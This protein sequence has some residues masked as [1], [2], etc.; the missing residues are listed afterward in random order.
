MKRR[1]R[2]LEPRPAPRWGVALS[3]LVIL[4]V[5]LFAPNGKQREPV[6]NEHVAQTRSLEFRVAN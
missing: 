5:V 2:D 4:G 1:T 3:M 6:F